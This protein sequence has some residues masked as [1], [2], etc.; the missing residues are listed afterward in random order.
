ML[1]CNIFN[2]LNNLLLHIL[3]L[4]DVL[5]H[6]QACLARIHESTHIVSDPGLLHFCTLS[7][8]SSIL[9]MHRSIWVRK[10]RTSRPLENHES[11]GLLR[12]PWKITA[13]IYC[14]A[15]IGPPAKH[16]NFL[17]MKKNRFIRQHVFE[18]ND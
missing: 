3:L 16:G 10:V 1:I 11:I 5:V 14:W 17:K 9:S 7:S 2:V 18:F 15:I 4:Q 6:I 12:N 8:T 13:S